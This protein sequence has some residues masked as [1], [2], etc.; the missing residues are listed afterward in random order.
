VPLI[1]QL[2]QDEALVHPGLA[3]RGW[4]RRPERII[5]HAGRG[6]MP[7]DGQAPP[8]LII[9]STGTLGRAFERVARERGLVARSVSRSE[10]DITDPVA[11]LALV[12]RV[13]PWAVVNAAGF[14]RVDD[15]ERE[16]RAC[17]E[18]NTLGAAH[19]AA[20]CSDQGVPLV[21]YSSDLVFDGEQGRPYTEGDVPR[22][23]NVYGTSK[24]EAERRVLAI[25]PSALVVR[26]S[27]FFG[28][29]DSSNFLIR[30][31]R[32][33]E[34]GESW[35][36]AADVIVSPTYVPDL[37]HATLD[38]LLDGERGLWH[39]TNDG[40]MSWF[41]FARGAAVACGLPPGGVQSV[42]A[43]GLGWPAPRPVY[44]ALSSIRGRLMRSTHDAVAA[45]AA[46]LSLEQ[47]SVV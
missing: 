1:R 22:P 15:A 40:A 29:W 25:L 35:P 31:L 46:S 12:A 47:A 14:V 16:A 38:L 43:D 37:V 23:L 3:Q 18:V 42:P 17:F 13:Q 5:Y 44:S 28:P 7:E 20:A 10:L 27:A 11:V 19:V 4:W 8:L 39:L 36:A 41:E 34:R 30:S 21:T 26:T 24:A 45:F 2:A 32:A 6:A 33:L 9:G